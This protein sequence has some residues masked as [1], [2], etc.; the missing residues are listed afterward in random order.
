VNG[1]PGYGGS[2]GA[3]VTI[4]NVPVTQSTTMTLS[5][6]GGGS[7]GISS[8][9][10]AKSGYRS[11]IS[12]DT[13]T[14]IA[15]GGLYGVTKSVV[16]P[17]TSTGKYVVD[18]SFTIDTANSAVMFSGNATSYVGGGATLSGSDGH[19][20]V[21]LKIHNVTV[22]TSGGGGSGSDSG[23]SRNGVKCKFGGAANGN[24]N[25]AGNL[26][27][28][29]QH[30]TTYGGGGGGSSSGNNNGGNGGPGVIMLFIY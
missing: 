19:L 6:G 30:C 21:T 3:A 4:V 5:V 7:G 2:G 13:K 11:S 15:Y 18:S 20:G 28:T 26:S 1:T 29:T 25:G 10:A 24:L 27:T 16:D 12:Y 9:T 14:A 23:T 17:I 22:A 8:T